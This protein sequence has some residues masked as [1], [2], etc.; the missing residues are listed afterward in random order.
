MSFNATATDTNALPLTYTWD[1]GDG[2]TIASGAF[3]QHGYNIE[4][5]FT[6]TLTVTDGTNT[7]VSSALISAVTPNSGGEGITNISQTYPAVM[8][9]LDGLAIS[10][11][12]SDG[13][14]IQLNIDVSSLTRDV[15]NVSTDFDGLGGRS[16]PGLRPIKKFTTP[17]INVA[18]VNATDPS[19]GVLVGKG[20]KTLVIG[21][22]EVGQTVAYTALPQSQ[23]ATKVSLSGKFSFSTTSSQL[24]SPL[25]KAPVQHPDSVTFGGTIELPVGARSFDA[26]NHRGGNWKYSRSGISGQK[27]QGDIAVSGLADS[28]T[29]G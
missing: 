5:D 10:I 13:G 6:V 19:T 1:F 11:A 16:V 14:V 8:D 27:R 18:L 3:V 4:G 28:E 26:A 17:G 12:S 2:S 23:K 22:A 21:S 29:P 25:A 20:R 9:P 24:L 7:A 15:P